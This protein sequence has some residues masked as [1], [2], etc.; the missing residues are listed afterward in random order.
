MIKRYGHY[1]K[2]ALK[3]P[4]R[5]QL[6]IKTTATMP[7]RVLAETLKRRQLP[8]ALDI[9]NGWRAGDEYLLV[10]LDACRWDYY[11]ARSEGLFEQSARPA[12]S[13]GYDTFQYVSRSWSGY[14]PDL[15][16]VSGATPVAGKREHEFETG[17][18]QALY[19]GYVPVD[20]IPN[21]VDVWAD[22][23]DPSVGTVPP[24]KVAAEA[25]DQD[26]AKMV[27]HMFQ[28]HAPYIGE[29][30]LLGH[31]GTRSAKPGKGE[32]VDAPLWENVHLGDVSD[33]QLRA[34]YAANLD[35]ALEAVC[36][37]LAETG[38]NALVVG[39]HGEALGEYGIYAHP[40]KSHP[41]IREVPAAV[42]SDVT[43]EGLE[44]AARAR[45]RYQNLDAGDESGTVEERLESLG[46]V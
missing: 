42:V 4:Q 29:F 14:Y 6:A 8:A 10:V 15:T 1:A 39:D 5:I 32:P 40:R 46:Y 44:A 25:I 35:R 31:H 20:H 21:I 18:I 11:Q 22:E 33:A 7:A 3:D 37:L 13:T 43:A 16:Y 41:K 2:Q 45:E 30:E 24:E 34:A 17:D 26:A 36:W 19:D 23:W 9:L 28:P 27:A 38:R 12:F